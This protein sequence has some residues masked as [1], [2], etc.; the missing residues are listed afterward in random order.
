LDAH[1]QQHQA[2]PENTMNQCF[3]WKTIGIPAPQGSKRHVGMG[4]MIESCKA[5][6]PWREQI[7]A[8]AQALGLPQT[9]EN[10]VSV[11]LVFCFPRPKS[12]FTSKGVLRSTA[13]SHKTTKPDVD[14]LCRAVLDALTIAGIIK[15]DSLVTTL[16]GQKR[17]CVGTEPP[18]VL[19]TIMDMQEIPFN[20]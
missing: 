10:A 14:K 16:S 9:I 18:G 7:V 8:D 2:S 3:S 15:D 12:H 4:R 1:W 13:P 5:L 20:D 11:S 17:Y 6:K 19:I